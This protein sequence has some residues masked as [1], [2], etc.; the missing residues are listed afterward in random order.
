VAQNPARLLSASRQ[1]GKE[2][3]ARF[4]KATASGLIGVEGEMSELEQAGA[5]ARGHRVVVMI[6][7]GSLFAAAAAMQIEIDYAKLLAY[8]CRQRSLIHAYFY[9]GV[10]SGNHKQMAFLRWMRNHGYRVIQKELV[11][12]ADGTRRADL[13]VEI[14]VDMLRFA[15]QVLEAGSDS[16]IL[17]TSNIDLRYAVEMVCNQGIRVELLGL[18][19]STAPELIDCVD[20]FIDLTEVKAL[21]QRANA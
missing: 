13:N 4:S 10:S 1:S 20:E 16:L 18:R 9:T 2:R 14:A 15:S 5:D 19:S 6:D 11:V 3:F 7:G 21:I 17:I 8:L 12:Q